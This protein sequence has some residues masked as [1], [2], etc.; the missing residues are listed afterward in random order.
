MATEYLLILELFDYFIY[1]IPVYTLELLA[2]I[3]GSI[4][5][6]KN[7][8]TYANTKYFVWYLWL[9]FVVE[10][11]GAYAPILYF[12][13]Y[14]YF[15]FIEATRF[16][17]NN[18]LYNLYFAISFSFYP[19]Y[20]SGF[21]KEKSQK[22]MLRLI[23]LLF[24]VIAVVSFTISDTFFTE[25]S[26]FVNLV[27]TLM[28]L[29]SVI[30]FYFELLRSNLILNLKKFLPLYMSFGLIVFYLCVTP[31]TIFSQYFNAENDTFVNLQVQIILYSNLFMYS[32]FILGF[33]SCSRKKKF[34]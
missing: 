12:T 34:Y 19:I 21:L 1:T 32:V 13:D 10:I 30:M 15:S 31:L 18:W 24:L 2:A 7:P 9:T 26:K 33:I 27:G 5:L 23:A 17:R 20:F 29:L 25:D 11:L 8:E 3:A 4:F 22:Y 14:K 28:L 16:V 6:A